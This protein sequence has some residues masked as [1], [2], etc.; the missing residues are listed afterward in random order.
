MSILIKNSDYRTAFLLCI[1]I[2]VFAFIKSYLNITLLAY[3]VLLLIIICIF[4]VKIKCV[5]PVMLFLL[6]WARI[7]KVDSSSITFLTLIL[8]FVLFRILATLKEDLKLDFLS[9]SLLFFLF[10]FSLLGS[11]ISGY[12]LGTSTLGFFVLLFYMLILL[13]NKELLPSRK[14][15]TYLFALSLI[16][17]FAAGMVLQG[18]PHMREYF[19]I[20]HVSGDSFLS[21]FSSLNFDPNYN[22]LQVAM[23]ISMLMIKMSEDN[24]RNLSDLVILFLLI[25][26]GILS[27]SKMFIIMLIALTII[28]ILS[29]WDSKISGSRKILIIVFM[30]VAAIYSYY[31]GILS[32]QINAYIYRFASATDIS[33]LTSRRSLIQVNYLN[34]IFDNPIVL[35]LGSGFSTNASIGYASHNTYIQIIF[36]IGIFGAIM[37]IIFIIKFMQQM[38]PTGQKLRMNRFL[39]LISLMLGAGALDLLLMDEF[40]YY[41]IIC[42]VVLLNEP[43]AVMNCDDLVTMDK[44]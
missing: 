39:P 13:S 42:G 10:S 25:G 18:L 29:K 17:A 43:G 23:G 21:R 14:E 12:D 9:L 32:E 33:T 26:I 2:C 15:T 5:L 34:Y 28:W 35:F 7:L 36:Q 20:A 8:P 3:A 40:V 37:L 30:A 16:I 11:L 4:K 41:I 44:I 38:K 31:S 6:P 1:S 27:L 19:K 24:K 22:A